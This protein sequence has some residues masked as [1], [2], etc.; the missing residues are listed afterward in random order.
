M[1]GRNRSDERS[2]TALLMSPS[3]PAAVLATAERRG[4][5]LG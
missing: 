5:K 3:R 4:L 1:T 2:L